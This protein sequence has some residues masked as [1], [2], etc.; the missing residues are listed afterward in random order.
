MAGHIGSTN[1]SLIILCTRSVYSPVSWLHNGV[2]SYWAFEKYKC[3]GLI[4]KY[5]D[6]IEMEYTLVIVI[7]NLNGTLKCIQG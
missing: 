6:V 4:P 7:L 5:P 1:S 2:K 3:L